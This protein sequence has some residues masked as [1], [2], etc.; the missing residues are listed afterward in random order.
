M[1]AAQGGL[2]D[3]GAIVVGREGWHPG[4]IGIVASRLAETYHRPADRRRA[5]RR[6]SARARPGRSPGFNL[7]EAIKACSEGLIGFGGHAAA[8]GLK[9]A[10]G[11]LP[12]FAERF[13]RHCR[14]APDRPSNCRRCSTIDAEVP[15][16]M[17]TL[18]VVEEIERSSRTASATRGRCWW[19]AGV[20]VVG[21]P[22]VVGDRKNHL[23][24]A[25]AQGDAIVKAIAWNMA[26]RGKALTAGRRL[27]ARVPP[28]DQRVE[29]PP[30]GPARGQG[31]PARRGERPCPAPAQ[32]DRPD[33]GRGDR[34]AGP[35]ARGHATP[36]SSTALAAVSRARFLPPEERAHADDDRAVP[37]GLRP[38]DQPAVHGRRDDR[39]AGP[40]RAPSASWRSA[41]AAATRRPSWPTWPPRSSPSSGSRRSRSGPAASSTAWA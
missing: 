12:A 8:A 13:D 2:G 32:P 4:V 16:G 36:A 41:P 39:R 34:P 9:L 28:V 5:R 30:R 26:E 7:Y 18:R 27:L 22:R 21:E 23:Q 24:S 35:R 38:D 19:P 6:A 31:L 3:R 25:F 37:I 10:R 17:L 15:L 40:D 11:A 14:A 1:I 33:P 20:R 29:R